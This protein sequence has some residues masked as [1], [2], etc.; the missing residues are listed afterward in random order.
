MVARARP[1]SPS[2]A[3]ETTETDERGTDPAAGWLTRERLKSLVL[4]CATAVVAWLSF[5]L[6]QPFFP[7]VT[8]ALALAVVGYPVHASIE[9]RIPATSFAAGLSTA[10]M[11]LLLAV[12]AGFVSWQLIRQAQVSSQN[13]KDMSAD[14]IQQPVRDL[15]QS[16]QHVSEVLEWI[17]QHVDIEKELFAAVSWV[18]R[19]TP[20][21]LTGTAWFVMQSL[22][23]VMVL[24]YFFRDH[25]ALRQSLRRLLP[26]SVEESEAVFARVDQTIH[27]AVY[28]SLLVGAIQGTMGGLMFWWLK[29][30]AP[31]LWGAVMGLL[32]VIPNMGTFVVW[33]PTAAALCLQGEWGRG[34]TLAAWG[35][36]AIGLIDNL[37]YPVLVGKNLQM[38]PLL[39]FFAVLGGLSVFGISGVVVGPVCIAILWGLIDIWRSRTRHGATADSATTPHPATS[40]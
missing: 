20:S 14:A 26:M 11:V 31:L 22:I 23:M 32:A 1:H 28:G 40:S 29:L 30:P 38:H 39:I 37:L 7:A 16:N 13:L 12:P 2:A 4:L 6:I 15:A 18:S 33:A 36:I 24:F 21:L 5:L 25:A 9:R 3:K 35:A 17:Q 8:W 34:L 10:V 27:A 19:S